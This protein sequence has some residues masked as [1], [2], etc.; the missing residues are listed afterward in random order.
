MKTISLPCKELF[1]IPSHLVYLDGNSLGPPLRDSAELAAHVV[2]EEWGKEL[3]NAWNTEDWISLPVTVSNQIAPIVGAPQDSISAGDTLSI[4][5]YQALAAALQMR[6][7]RQIVLSDSGNFPTDLYIAQGLIDLIDKSHKLLTPAP[8]EVLDN[9]TEEVAVVYLTHVDY[10]TGRMHDMK[11]IT[12]KAHR[13][14]AVTIWDLAHSVGAVPLELQETQTEFA[15]GCTY[16]YLNGGPGAPAFIYVRPDVVTSIDPAIAGWMGHKSPFAMS[17]KYDPVHSVERFRIGTPSVVQFKLLQRAL[18]VWQALDMKEVRK[19]SVRLGEL[20]IDE[21]E[22]R[23]PMLTLASPRSSAARGSQVSFSYANSYSVIQA[24]SDLGLIGDF[25]EP[26]IMRFGITPL[27][28]DEGDI[29]R[30][31][32]II[33]QVMGDETWRRPQYEVRKTVT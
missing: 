2:S 10:R 32:R 9:I 18:K 12:E 3:I 19:R 4:K 21:V 11:T 13:V 8:E 1:S 29:T 6:P 16:K 26:N 15:V 24:L 7:N 28:L 5:A 27:Y 20:F 25:R 17:L 22:S 31:A 23:C 30:A 14:G 33:E